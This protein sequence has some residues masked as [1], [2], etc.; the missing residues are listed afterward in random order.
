MKNVTRKHKAPLQ[1]IPTAEPW[2]HVACDVVVPLLSTP[3]GKK[4]TV[5][6]QK[7]LTAWSEAFAT[8]TT[9]AI[10]IAILLLDNIIFRNGS[11]RIFSAN[12][13]KN[14]LLKLGYKQ[15]EC[16]PISSTNWRNGGNI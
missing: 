5:V 12:R 2:Q 4:Y 3:L 14:F 1:S 13:A 10:F 11:P 7:K 9:N 8:Y 15:K 6:F 16:K